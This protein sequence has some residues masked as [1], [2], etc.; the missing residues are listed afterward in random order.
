MRVRLDTLP[1]PT[2]N[3]AR[4]AVL[5]S[6]GLDSAV[7]ARLADQ[8]LPLDEPIDLLNVAFESPRTT[9]AL[10]MDIYDV[11]DRLTAR[12]TLAELR[13]LSVRSLL[14]IGSAQACLNV[15]TAFTELATS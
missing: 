6:G 12:L 2:T 4:L 10:E 1:L 13:E 5:F 8:L 7:L 14:T 3:A 11:P 15:R 9:R